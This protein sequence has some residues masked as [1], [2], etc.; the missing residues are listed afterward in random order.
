MTEDRI[1]TR[2]GAGCSLYI[3]DRDDDDRSLHNL[4]NLHSRTVGHIRNRNH[5]RGQIRATIPDQI[6]V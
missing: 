1:T 6:D 5:L 3:H 2:D 4:H